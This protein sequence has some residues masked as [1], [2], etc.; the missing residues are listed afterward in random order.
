MNDVARLTE[1]RFCTV[2]SNVD[3]GAVWPES[4]RFTTGGLVRNTAQPEVSR[5]HSK[6]ET[7][8]IPKEKGSGEALQKEEGLNVRMAQRTGSLW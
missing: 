1:V 6:P 8:S 5:G 2:R 7:S 3:A 4:G